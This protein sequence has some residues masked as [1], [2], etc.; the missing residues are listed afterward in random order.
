MKSPV[1]PLAICS[2]TLVG[3]PQLVLAVGWGIVI[4]VA[5]RIDPLGLSTMAPPELL[6]AKPP[7]R[8]VPPKLRLEAAS[9][10]PTITRLLKGAKFFIFD[11]SSVKTCGVLRPRT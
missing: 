9:A 4:D 2:Q 1:M 11:V 5:D 8:N 10:I 7:L 3:V 6:N